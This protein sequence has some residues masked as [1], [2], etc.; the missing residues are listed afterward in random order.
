[1]NIDIIGVAKRFG[2]FPA[3]H[4]VDLAIRS[5]ELVA[6]LGPSG[7]GKT[8]LL[9]ILAGLEYPDGG[10]V[11]FDGDDVLEISAR[12]R[13]VGFVFQ[14]Y[15]LFRHMRVFDNVAFGPRAVPRR[16]R[17]SEDDIRR[18]VESLLD[19]VKIGELAQRFPGQLSGGQRQRVALAR[20]LATEPRVLLLDEPFGA[21]DAK[22]RKDL[23]RWLRD[24][25]SELHV[26]SVLVTHDQEEALE[27]ADRI[28]V[29]QAGQIEQEGTPAEVYEHPATAFVHD[30]IGESVVLPVEIRAGA[31]TLAG[32]ALP[33]D[34]QGAPDGPARLFVRPHDLRLVDPE[35]APIAARVVAK[36][37]VGAACRLEAEVTG[38]AG[39][40]LVE[41]IAP[42]DCAIA[43]GETIGLAP[44][45][46]RIFAS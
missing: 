29:M 9:R 39:R 16:R 20:A 44:E 11:R 24:L 19:L 5:G 28:V 1:M 2:S 35:A 46:Y 4:G 34:R 43:I 10:E 6:L 31:V 3:L 41:S 37:G 7:S 17:L 8:T 26:T 15:A 38:D 14:H 27:I 32:R 18:K 22:V 12:D 42:P 33:L 40:T 21:L 13:H 36:R 25:H 23:R 30:F 45:R